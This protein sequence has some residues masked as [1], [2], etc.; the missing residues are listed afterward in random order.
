MILNCQDECDREQAGE[1]RVAAISLHGVGIDSGLHRTSKSARLR[2]L[3]ALGYHCAGL[4]PET[5]QHQIYLPAPEYFQSY[6][7]PH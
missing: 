1:H 3:L 2:Q 6:H 5:I 7:E 4:H